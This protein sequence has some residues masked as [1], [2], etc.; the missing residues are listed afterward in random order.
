MKA[1]VAGGG[2]A[3]QFAVSAAGAAFEE[4]SPEE[5]LEV[6]GEAVYALFGSLRA[7]LLRMIGLPMQ[8]DRQKEWKLRNAQKQQMEA[9][10]KR[11][12]ADFCPQVFFFTF[13]FDRTSMLASSPIRVRELEQ[14]AWMDGRWVIADASDMSKSSDFLHILSKA[15]E[16]SARLTT[17]AEDLRRRPGLPVSQTLRQDVHQLLLRFTTVRA[18]FVAD[19]VEAGLGIPGL[20]DLRQEFAIIG[21]IYASEC[22]SLPGFLKSVEDQ[23]ATQSVFHTDKTAQEDYC[24]K[25]FLCVARAFI[26]GLRGGAAPMAPNPLDDPSSS[27]VGTCAAASVSSHALVQTSQVVPASL[28][29]PPIAGASTW[30]S[31]P[32]AYSLA[33]QPQDTL[34]SGICDGQ[35]TFDVMARQTAAG[36][37]AAGPLLGGLAGGGAEGLDL[38]PP[39]RR[40]LHAQQMLCGMR[41]AGA[42][43]SMPPVGELP[44]VST[45]PPPLVGAPPAPTPYMGISPLARPPG[46][47]V[48]SQPPSSFTIGQ[49]SSQRF[50]TGTGSG[51]LATLQ[52]PLP[53]QSDDLYI[54]YSTG[55]LGSFSP[56][57]G[58]SF[59]A[60]MT[61][62]ECGAVQHHYA[63]ECPARFVRV[64]GEPPP[65]WKVDAQGAVVKD[66][67][68]WN[69]ADLTDATRAQF[70]S[71]ID[72]LSLVPHGGFPVS[73]D[74]ILGPAPVPARRPRPKPS[75]PQAWSQGWGQR[76]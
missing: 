33:Q 65:G 55:L 46:M 5:A 53:G 56:Y 34:L 16:L 67:A 47:P 10:G 69:G 4:P 30:S 51:S 22:A 71:F 25:A 23:L 9:A 70:R 49:R 44:P 28:P 39:A 64:R 2:V 54:P 63:A 14:W 57:R 66:H 7:S 26:C 58:L 48:G 74:E 61:C 1:F 11:V 38:P 31:L 19:V 29:A 35:P 18:R 21:R 20:R 12:P 62:F 68:A 52:S 75:A 37:R 41:A 59:P 73:R 17:F 8:V 76:R 24:S 6:S 45:Y 15:D 13:Q 72:K 32:P 3:A 60:S 36:Y 40:V 50:S 42:L 27:A 43:I